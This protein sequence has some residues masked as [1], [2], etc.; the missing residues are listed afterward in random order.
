MKVYISGKITGL[1]KE[2][3]MYNFNQAERFLKKRGYS[4]INPA[5]VNGELPEDTT[6]YEEYMEVSLKLLSFCD[7]IFMLSDWTDSNGATIEWNYAMSHGIKAM[8]ESIERK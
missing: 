7:A 1:P 4:V 3:Y 6:T 8:Y 2:E 5:R